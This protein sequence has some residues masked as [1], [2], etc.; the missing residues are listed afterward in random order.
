MSLA[1]DIRNAY[2]GH[3]REALENALRRLSRLLREVLEADPGAYILGTDMHE[4]IEKN[5]ED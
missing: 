2:E 1:T 3:D 4:R 5:I